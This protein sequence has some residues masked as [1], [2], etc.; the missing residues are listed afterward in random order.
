MLLHASV[1]DHHQGARTWTWLKL[2]F[3]KVR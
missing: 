2:Q 3:L 1:Y